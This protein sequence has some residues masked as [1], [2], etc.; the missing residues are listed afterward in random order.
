MVG[1]ERTCIFH[2]SQSLDKVTQKYI[3]TSLQFHHKQLCKDYKDAKTID[4]AE[5]KYHVICSWWLN[6]E[7]PQKKAFSAYP[8]GWD[9][10]TFVKGNGVVT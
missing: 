7:L 5:T 4:E 6:P 1:S 3:K 9:F 2:W 8:S 10:G